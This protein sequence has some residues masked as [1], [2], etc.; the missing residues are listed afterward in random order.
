M[1]L[2]SREW[3]KF[4]CRRLHTFAVWLFNIKIPHTH[5]LAMNMP[6][7]VPIYK[8]AFRFLYESGNVAC[9]TSWL[10]FGALLYGSKLHISAVMVVKG[11]GR[12][13]GWYI[14]C[15]SAESIGVTERVGILTLFVLYILLIHG[16][17][18]CCCCVFFLYNK[19]SLAY[20]PTQ[21]L[22]WLTHTHMR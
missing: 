13:V 6:A 20:Q 10:L 4:S 2:K 22:S 7:F 3:T 14:V 19:N 11:G 12:G 5:S 18:Y 1:R 16:W 21:L 8:T 9:T 15:W 17:L